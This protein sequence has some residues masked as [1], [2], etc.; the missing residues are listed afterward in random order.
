MELIESLQEQIGNGNIQDT[1]SA[2]QLEAWANEYA[3][4]MKLS[5]LRQFVKREEDD[6]ILR[7]S[8]LGRPAV[9]QALKITSVYE[10]LVK[11]GLWV[12]EQ[13]TL[14]MREVFHRGDQF[15]AF[16]LFHLKRLGYDVVSTQET[17]T[18]MGV[19]GHT[20]AIIESSGQR[21][22]LEVKTMSD[23]YFRKFTKE[24]DDERGY[25]TQMALYSDCVALPGV[26]VCLNKGTHEIALVVPNP[27]ALATAKARAER[28]I[29]IFSNVK[30]FE[31]VITLFKAPPTV[32]EVYQR[33]K[34]GREMLNPSI[35]YSP[36]R[37]LFYHIFE[38]KNGYGKPT[39]YVADYV[40]VDDLPETLQNPNILAFTTY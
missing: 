40:T 31:D 9:L 39:E 16:L 1:V 26:W 5:L 11:A 20:D 7:I 14:K 4:A 27:D 8:S 2:E 38:E 3:E 35:K 30:Y 13:P 21:L 36:F 15:E 37:N 19:P 10:Q 6:N 25:L 23:S 34:T 33:K 22:L 12:N 17:V 29:P 18:F 24:P 32:P 28:I